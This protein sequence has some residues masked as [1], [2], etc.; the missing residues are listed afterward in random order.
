MELIPKYFD[1]SCARISEAVANMKSKK[2][3]DDA[4]SS[5]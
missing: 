3:S 2:S 5:S 1:L 4:A